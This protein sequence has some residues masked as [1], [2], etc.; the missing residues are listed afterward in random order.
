MQSTRLT[1]DIPG[2]VIDAMRL[3][4]EDIEKEILK[5]LALALYQ[6]KIVSLGIARQLAQMTRW[7]F[8]ELLGER[9]IPRHY[10]IHDAQ[11]DIEYGL[12]GK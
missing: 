12:G 5:E 3:P 2:E 7:D 6:R 8:E 11:E 10:T 1:L 9:N 4:P